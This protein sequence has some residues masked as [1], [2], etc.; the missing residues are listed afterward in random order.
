MLLS[1][2]WQATDFCDLVGGRRLSNI[3]YIG[4]VPVVGT[5]VKVEWETGEPVVKSAS[6]AV[7]TAA[8]AISYPPSTS[9]TYESGSSIIL[10]IL[11]L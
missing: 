9:I 4:G 6:G 3:R 11:L 7:S 2:M 5:T 8:G 10:R 1:L